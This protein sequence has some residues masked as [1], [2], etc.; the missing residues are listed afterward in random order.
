MVITNILTKKAF[1]RGKILR[2]SNHVGSVR[3]SANKLGR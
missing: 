1:V 2:S 3:A